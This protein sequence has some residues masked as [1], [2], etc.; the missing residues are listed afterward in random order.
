VFGAILATVRAVS[1]AGYRFDLQAD[2]LGE[3]WRIDGN[4]DD[5]RGPGRVLITV[6][7]TGAGWARHPC[8]DPEFKAGAT[9]EERRLPDG[10]R[11]VRRG[12]SDDHGYKTIIVMVVRDQGVSVH[13]ETGNYRSPIPT[14]DTITSVSRRLKIT[15]EH[16]L[17]N[18]TQLQQMVQTIDR[19]IQ[20][21]IPPRC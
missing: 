17:Y 5:G 3:E 9:C 11:L 1:P 14:P 21:C 6:S 2:T 10:T 8:S 20:D 15:R 7:R 16:P 18:L 13:A 12:V 4:V 19:T